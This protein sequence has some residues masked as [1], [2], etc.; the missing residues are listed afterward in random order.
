MTLKQPPHRSAH[1]DDRFLILGLT[2]LALL[3]RLWGINQDLWLDEI[4]TL[5]HN[6]RLPPLES[7]ATF[8]S[9]NQH[10]LNS[11][12]GGLSIRLFGESAWA[13]RLPALLFGVAIIPVFY[14][15]AR[16]VCTRFEAIFATLFMTLSYH[17]VWFS[18]N[19][20]GYSAMIFFTVLSTLFL[21]RWLQQ[22][23]EGSTRALWWFSVCGALGM[24]SLLNYAF[25]LAG[26]LL[27]A[28]VVMAGER[29][30]S[31]FGQL[32]LSGVVVAGLSLL[33]YAQALPAMLDYF[34]GG[35]EQMG[36]T[37]PLEFISVFA[38]GFSQAL[39]AWAVPGLFFGGIIALTGWFSYLKHQRMIALMLLLPP[40]FNVT[41][42][43]ILDF[44]AYPRSFLYIMPFGILILI[45][46]AFV[47]GAWA[48][49]LF[50]RQLQLHYL[51]PLLLL[52]ASALMLPHNYRY[53]KQDY[54]GALAYTR[55]QA[56]PG[57]II[58]AVG[59]LAS[60]YRNLYAPELAF[61]KNAGELH[62]LREKGIRVW[63][64]YSFTR[65][66]RRHFPDIQDYLESEFQ[67][68]RKFPGTLGDGTV[69]LTVSPR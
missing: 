21:L 13:A 40:L 69:Y 4:A 56:A 68:E 30:P 23:N 51:A 33:G 59:Y 32:L 65:D 22:R 60:G 47:L 15:L 57:D 50:R 36:W 34:L 6:M 3:L 16:A 61:P 12:L 7:L 42:L 8:K 62:E 39:P 25:V 58:A 20:R 11:I 45:R 53:P 52:M 29:H 55:A 66:M 27:A 43:T 41:A 38:Q 49:G 24:L 46:G 9:A 35:G 28:F 48:N 44:G 14:I 67:P 17:H 31:K 63:V 54:T 64:L 10:M 26:Q 18:Q 19:A 2:T 5:V 37:N 1:T